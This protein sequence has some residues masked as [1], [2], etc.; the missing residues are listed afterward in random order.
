MLTVLLLQKEVGE[1][2]FAG[3]SYRLLLKDELLYEL[4]T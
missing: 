1:K 3:S 2:V 4:Y